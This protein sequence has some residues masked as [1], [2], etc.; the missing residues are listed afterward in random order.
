MRHDVI[1]LNP[2]FN[3]FPADTTTAPNDVKASF[4]SVTGSNLDMAP[5]SASP[6]PV[7]QQPVFD[8]ETVMLENARR[9][10]RRWRQKEPGEG[11]HD[12]FGTIIF[13]LTWI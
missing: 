4:A 11:K 9:E 12:H 3:Q 7:P 5:P 10:I 1:L 8:E 6:Q 2:T 13:M